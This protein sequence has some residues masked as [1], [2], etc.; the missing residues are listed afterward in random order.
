MNIIINQKTTQTQAKNLQEI[1]EELSLP[2][3]G[4]AIAIGNSIVPRAQWSETPLHEN[5]N[6]V[7][8]KAACGG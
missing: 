7:I 4:V 6:I 1:A 5:D 3:K 8:I 2:E